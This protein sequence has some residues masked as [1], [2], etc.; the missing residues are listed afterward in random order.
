MHQLCLLCSRKGF[1]VV[2]LFGKSCCKV[3]VDRSRK[4][5][6]ALSILACQDLSRISWRLKPH[7]FGTENLGGAMGDGN[8][9]SNRRKWEGFRFSTGNLLNHVD[10]LWSIHPYSPS[11]LYPGP[12]RPPKL[13]CSKWLLAQGGPPEP[14]YK[15]AS[16]RYDR[17]TDESNVSLANHSLWL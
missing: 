16:S 11:S 7:A 12:E 4:L 2:T 6:V 14:A 13:L 1:I 9:P 15:T 5:R 8:K 10:L 17:R 3:G